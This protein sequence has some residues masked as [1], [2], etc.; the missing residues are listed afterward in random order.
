LAREEMPTVRAAI[1]WA[2]GVDPPLAIAI[3]CALERF[4]ATSHARE[5]IATFTALLERHPAPDTHRARALRCRGGCRYFI[6]DFEGG[7]E[8]YEAALAIHRR[9]GERA[10]EAHLDMR[11]AMDA[12]RV[13]DHRRAQELLDD[14]AAVGGE[15]RFTPDAYVGLGLAAD[16]AFAAGRAEEG[17]QMLDTAAEL[18]D[19]AGDEM[20]L[21][22][23]LMRIGERALDQRRIEDAGEAARRALGVAHRLEDRQATVYGLA[24][25]ARHAA[26]T[27]LGRRA[28][29]IWGGL[30]A[31]VDRSGPLGQWEMERDTY[32]ERIVT[33][34]GDAFEAG[35][36]EGRSLSLES[37]VDEALS[38]G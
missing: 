13:G 26:E 15:N 22:D 8:D 29:R 18:A 30:E 7:V 25:L 2:E 17:F 20:W 28:G 6:G 11:L 10:H 5:G 35:V 12:Y 1:A 9:Q 37:V 19:R 33:P 21:H 34:A 32:R 24:L 4:W 31:E 16:L 23:S 38:P 36:A 14:A 27:G 3:A